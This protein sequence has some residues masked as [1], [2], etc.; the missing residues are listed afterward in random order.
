VNQHA[1][2]KALVHNES[3][4]YTTDYISDQIDPFMINYWITNLQAKL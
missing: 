4:V 2:V 3:F 1:V